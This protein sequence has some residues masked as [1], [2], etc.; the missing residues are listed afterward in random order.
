MLMGSTVPENTVTVNAVMMGP[1]EAGRLVGLLRAEPGFERAELAGPP[2]PLTGGFWASMSLLRLAHVAPPADTLVLRVMPDTALAAK[3]TVFQREIGRQG[4]PVPAVRLSGGAGAGV[5]GAFLVMDYAPGAP[6]LGGLGGIAALRRLPVLAH[7]LPHLLGQVT[8]GLH[9]LDPAPL[10]AALAEARIA[11]PS[12]APAFLS[13]L[14]ESAGRLGRADLCAAARWLA[15]HL[16]AAGPSVIGHGDLHPFNLLT[17][18]ERWTL[19]DWTSALIADPA[20]DLAFTALTLRHPPLA[21][22]APLRPVIGAAGAALAR[23][24]LA[25][26]RSAGGTVPDQPA[27]DWYAGLHAL[28]IL[29]ELDSWRHGPGGPGHSFHPWMAMGPVA[30]QILTRTMDTKVSLIAT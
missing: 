19:L 5:G 18:R 20:Y 8:A 12:D 22:P 21:A 14:D 4:F 27:L 17:Q 23:R 24:F 2:Q 9:A 11:A 29:I 16:P 28:R 25:A 10:R 26:Y 7:Q 13:A 15:G 3:E 1:E 30:A 6:L